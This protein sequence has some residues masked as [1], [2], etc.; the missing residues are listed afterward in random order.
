M[1]KKLFSLIIFGIA[2]GFIEASVVFYL[3][4]LL[5]HT[6]GYINGTYTTLFNLGLIAFILPKNPILLTPTL[7]SIETIREFS[8]IVMLAAISYLSSNTIRQK[9]G[10]FLVSFATWDIFY[11]IFLKILTGWPKGF[12]DID[13]FFLIPVPWVGPVIAPVIISIML[14]DVGSNLYLKG[15]EV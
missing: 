15:K 6:Y 11:Y 8:T 5:H 4:G 14:F 3:Q 9:I 12:M 10:A 1:N 13:I 7:T 2:F